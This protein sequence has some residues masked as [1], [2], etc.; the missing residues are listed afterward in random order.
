MQS[1]VTL[2]ETIEPIEPID[3][4]VWN[5]M[6]F[7]QGGSLAF[8]TTLKN[9]HL[10]LTV[11]LISPGRLFP[12]PWIALSPCSGKSG[13]RHSAP[14]ASPSQHKA[15]SSP[16]SSAFT[17]HS[18]TS[19]SSSRVSA[20]IQAWTPPQRTRRSLMTSSAR[21]GVLR[22]GIPGYHRGLDSAPHSEEHHQLSPSFLQ[23]P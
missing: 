18:P 10:H 1:T 13:P 8:L 23:F 14:M 20:P 15:T 16:R 5:T 9:L 17:Q 12:A 22:P 11:L 4:K 21:Y 3:F 2:M 7:P 6:L 19:I